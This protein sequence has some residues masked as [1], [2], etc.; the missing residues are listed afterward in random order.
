M[1]IEKF[2]PTSFDWND[3]SIEKNNAETGFAIN[4]TKSAG[5]ITVRYIEY[6]SNYIA[7]HWCEKGHIVFVI[8]GELMIE[9]INGESHHL[10]KGM[11]FIIGDNTLEHKAKS[12]VGAKVLIVD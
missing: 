1:I 12:E 11:T 7:D 3:V 10:K 4:R 8:S 6:S 9:H 2:H 5:N